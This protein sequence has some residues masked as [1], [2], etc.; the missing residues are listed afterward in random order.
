MT[1][2][3]EIQISVTDYVKLAKILRI[4]TQFMFTCNWLGKDNIN[5]LKIIVFIIIILPLQCLK[6]SLSLMD[7]LIIFLF[8]HRILYDASADI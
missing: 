6:Q 8:R 7:G 5:N 1:E 2:S 4:M 3:I